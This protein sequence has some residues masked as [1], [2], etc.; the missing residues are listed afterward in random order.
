M[1]KDTI[2]DI[3]SSLFIMLFLYT[4]ISKLLDFSSF[5][6]TLARSPI[7]KHYAPAI[8]LMI[9]LI[10]LVIVYLLLLPFFKSAS[11]TRTYGLIAACMLM[12]IFTLYIGYMLAFT[13][14]RPC[15]CGG[16]ISLMNWHQH[17]YFNTFFTIL[18]FVGIVLANKQNKRISD[19]M[20]LI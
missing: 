5:R 2:I 17:L 1:K 6:G 11:R 15:S 20:S 8:A 12:A 18:A 9:P 13:P 7:L 10:E 3:I 14:D 16:I 19:N 4:G